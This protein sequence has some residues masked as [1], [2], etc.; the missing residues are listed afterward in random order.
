M[1]ILPVVDLVKLF[2]QSTVLPDDENSDYN[3]ERGNLVLRTARITKVYKLMKL[4]RLI[5][6]FKLLK[7]K[8]K[9]EA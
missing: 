2:T 7:N 8:D 1:S 3:L 6:V 9:L 5:K 4:F